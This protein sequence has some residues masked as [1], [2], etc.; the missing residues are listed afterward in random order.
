M[1]AEDACPLGGTG[2]FLGGERCGGGCGGAILTRKDPCCRTNLPFRY[3]LPT[4]GSICPTFA[5][6]FFSNRR[7]GL[8]I[9]CSQTFEKKCATLENFK[10]HPRY[11]PFQTLGR[12]YQVVDLLDRELR[13]SKSRKRE[14]HGRPR[15]GALALGRDRSDSEEAADAREAH[16]RGPPHHCHL[17]LRRFRRSVWLWRAWHGQDIGCGSGRRAA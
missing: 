10:P 8:V 16:Q 14:R 5:T 15:R 12:N 17:R 6:N 3:A 7:C 11:N 9:S 2:V 1:V 4:I 13:T